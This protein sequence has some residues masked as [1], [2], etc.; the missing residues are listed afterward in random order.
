MER[1][2]LVWRLRR[3]YLVFRSYYKAH[4]EGSLFWRY[5]EKKVA[6]DN[7]DDD[8]ER[9]TIE[10]TM[11]D[12]KTTP[13]TRV[14]QKKCTVPQTKTISLEEVKKPFCLLQAPPC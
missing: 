2:P 10:M 9:K 6:T 11:E 12:I 7:N 13:T 8:A 5:A 4:K 1:K 14:Q 3:L